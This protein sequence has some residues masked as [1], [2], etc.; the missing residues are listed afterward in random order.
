MEMTQ[1]A[2]RSEAIVPLSAILGDYAAG[3]QAGMYLLT[4]TEYWYVASV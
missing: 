4:D 1:L 2:C 3:R